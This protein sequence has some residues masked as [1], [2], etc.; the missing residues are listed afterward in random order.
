MALELAGS[1]VRWTSER[2][3]LC[4]KQN[5]AYARRRRR[6]AYDPSGAERPVIQ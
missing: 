1:C 2:K 4:A 5:A 3:A 6:L